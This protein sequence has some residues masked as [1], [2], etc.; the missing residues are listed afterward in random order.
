[1][2]KHIKLNTLHECSLLYVNYIL[3]KLLPKKKKQQQ[4]TNK[5]H[6]P[7]DTTTCPSKWLKLNR[8]TT[9]IAGEDMKQV[10]ITHCWGECKMAQPPW[11]TVWQFLIFTPHNP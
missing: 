3:K 7:Q 2:S 8:L 1:M 6:I 10:K 11:K 5:P 4:Q 9:P